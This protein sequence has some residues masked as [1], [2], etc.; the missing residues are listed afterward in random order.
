M[1]IPGVIVSGM[2]R[3]LFSSQKAVEKGISTIINSDLPRL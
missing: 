1:Q 2:G 3:Q